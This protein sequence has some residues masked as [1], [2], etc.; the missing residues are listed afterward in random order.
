MAWPAG[1]GFVSGQEMLQYYV[2]YGWWGIA[3]AAVNL[4]VMLAGAGS[5]LN[6]QFGLP[7]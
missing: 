2:S 4:L 5:N 3:G 6:Q 1:V 7:L